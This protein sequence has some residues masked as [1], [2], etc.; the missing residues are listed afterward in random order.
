VN[1]TSIWNA[2]QS[3][4]ITIPD[5]G[6]DHERTGL[7]A[8]VT[9]D[10]QI[11]VDFD[12]FTGTATGIGTFL[13]I[14]IEIEETGASA[15]DAE[16]GGGGLSGVYLPIEAEVD[17]GNAYA[18][19][20]WDTPVR[21]DGGYYNI[22]NASPVIPADGWYTIS[23][24]LIIHSTEAGKIQVDVTVDGSLVMRL[25]ALPLAGD[26]TFSMS[27]SVSTYALETNAVFVTITQSGTPGFAVEVIGTYLSVVPA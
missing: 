1:G 20:E 27:G 26:E 13:Q 4:R 7:T 5:G 15:T 9:K 21:D 16:L 24:G 11:S 23:L 22:S 14:V 12:G 2:D 6:T 10:Q 25:Q 8:A 18:T 3:Q 17:Q 19:T